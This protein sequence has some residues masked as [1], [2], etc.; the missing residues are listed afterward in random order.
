MCRGISMRRKTEGR[1]KGKSGGR[2]LPLK[3]PLKTYRD[4]V[5]NALV[6]VYQ[7]T[8]NGDVLYVNDTFLRILGF[9]SQKEVVSTGSRAG[10]KN[11]DDREVMV[12]RLKQTGSLR[13][14]PVEF[15]SKSGKTIRVF[16]SATLSGDVISGMMM[17]VT[18]RERA[19]DKL[20]ESQIKYR[21]LFDNANGAIFLIRDG[22]CV[23]CNRAALSIFRSTKD[24]LLGKTSSDLSPPFQPDGSESKQGA[25]EREAAALAG[26]PQ[27]FEWRHRRHDGSVFDAEVSL[28]RV[29]IGGKAVL[30]A[31]IRDIS[32]RK[33]AENR[34]RISEEKYRSI[35]EN[36][37]DGIFQ[38][39]PDGKTITA[40]TALAKM[41]GYDSAQDLMD[42]V[43]DIATQQYVDPKA[44]ARFGDILSKQGFVEGFENQVYK[45]DR[46][47]IWTS[48][49]ARAVKDEKGNIQ[50][51]EGIMEDITRRKEVEDALRKTEERYRTFIDSTSDWVFLKDE[52][53]RHII[54]NKA[55]QSFF[56]KK[57]EEIIGKT[58]FELMPKGPAKQI[59]ESDR[60]ALAS[61]S[62]SVSE[63]TIDDR[64]YETRKFPVSLGDGKKGVGGFVRDMTERKRTEE[65]LKAKSVNLEEVN[66][67]L[68]V[69]L[70]QRDQDKKE[71][72]EKI[73]Y[74]VKKL[75]LPYLERLKQRRLDEEQRT[76]LDILETNLS[77]VVSPFVRKMTY[78]HS[79]F[80]PTEISVANFIKD[81]KTVKEIAQVFGVSENAVNRHRQS[82][83]N[84]LKLNR[85]KVNLK[86]FLMSLDSL[87]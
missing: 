55:L 20:R 6:G 14:Y 33:D 82:I 71:L 31:I 15:V 28:N 25:I 46:R 3:Q 43:T 79:H 27:F 32:D 53:F 10:Y 5:E 7:T 40:N 42:E 75:V 54:A 72:E 50:Y 44:R 51:Y 86:T 84:K 59:E 11:P 74:N 48:V 67:A 56:Q 29:I 18:E 60:K 83:R 80:T 36:A 30:Q 87:T 38:S 57:E 69:L 45:K 81:G 23:D 61:P 47:T 65:E 39:S 73:L 49:K 19:L 22:K 58:V 85:Q 4:I 34:L 16:L 9:E 62:V 66:A 12:S 76:Y 17:D 52:H 24:Q 26:T 41:F 8:L 37:V 63:V 78:M 21:T 70:K 77:N 1:S 35:F 2:A 13:N 68:K 64:V